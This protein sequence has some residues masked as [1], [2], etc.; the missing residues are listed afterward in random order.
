MPIGPLQVAASLVGVGWFK[1]AAVEG[2][3]TRGGHREKTVGSK[4]VR[5]A[6]L[7]KIMLEES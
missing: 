6:Y 3:T 1:H 2:R 7:V 4:Q 5:E